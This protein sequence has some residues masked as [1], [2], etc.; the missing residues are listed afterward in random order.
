MSSASHKCTILDSWPMIKDDFEAFTKNP[1]CWFI[2]RF[3]TAAQDKDWEMASKLIEIFKIVN[4]HEG[5]S[6]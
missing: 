2:E 6:H 3:E 5:H 4:S 1:T